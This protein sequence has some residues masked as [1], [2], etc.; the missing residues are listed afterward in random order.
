M[1]VTQDG[2]APT[3]RDDGG[4]D[5]RGL[6][7]GSVVIEVK[8]EPVYNEILEYDRECAIVTVRVTARGFSVRRFCPSSGGT[9]SGRGCLVNTKLYPV[10]SPACGGAG[11]LHGC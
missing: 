9:R 3:P 6:N 5:S 10:P 4:P 7:P 1:A 2:A 8:L 11:G